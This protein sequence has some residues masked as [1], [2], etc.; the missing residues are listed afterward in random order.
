[1]NA[2][3][4]AERNSR[5]GPDGFFESRTAVRLSRTAIS[6]QSFPPPLW[7]LFRHTPT[8][9]SE[10]VT[11]ILLSVSGLPGVPGGSLGDLLKGRIGAERARPQVVEFE[12]VLKNFRWLFHV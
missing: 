1:M 11:F 6:T 7:L 9:S 10:T 4:W 8:F 12:G 3:H 2:A 5:R